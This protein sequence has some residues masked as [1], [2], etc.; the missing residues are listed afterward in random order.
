MSDYVKSITDYGNSVLQSYGAN[1]VSN[2][3]DFVSSNTLITK[4]GFLILVVVL[5][6]LFLNLGIFFLHY[7]TSPASNPYIIKGQIAGNTPIVIKQDVSMKHAVQI[8]RSNNED[9]GMEFTWNLL[10]QFG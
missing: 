5:F 1:D 8:Q 2:S 3:S 4:F 7:F 6:I 9:T 10:G